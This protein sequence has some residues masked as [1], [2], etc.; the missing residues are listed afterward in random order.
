MS[1]RLGE[2]S[3]RFFNIK[4]N[5]SI[6][7]VK[8]HLASFIDTE[9][10]HPLLLMFEQYSDP[11]IGLHLYIKDNKISGY[12]EDGSLTR[13]RML[14]H[15]KPWFWGH[16]VKTRSGYTFKG[17]IQASPLIWVTYMILLLL[18]YAHFFINPHTW[19]M[20]VIVLSLCIPLFAHLDYKDENI[21]YKELLKEFE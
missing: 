15:N 11:C 13:Y 14:Q 3:M 19:G 18:T 9:E 10:H 6:S 7:D 20:D 2:N 1:Y 4:L 5:R 16:F 17:I 12:Y 21:L 8:N